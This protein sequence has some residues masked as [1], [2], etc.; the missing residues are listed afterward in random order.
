M[1]Q[2]RLWR[3]IAGPVPHTLRLF[4]SS[5]FEL[6]EVVGKKKASST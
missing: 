6:I 1:I 2:L 5:L 3:D 4:V